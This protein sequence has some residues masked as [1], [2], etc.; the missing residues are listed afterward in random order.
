MTENIA[1]K[2][3]VF[4]FIQRSQE[5]Y[6]QDATLG[7]VLGQIGRYQ[8][9]AKRAYGPIKNPLHLMFTSRVGLST[10]ALYEFTRSRGLPLPDS[11]KVIQTILPIKR[12]LRLTLIGGKDIL[13]TRP[14]LIDF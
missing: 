3:C 5:S 14:N 6:Q 13:D 8:K 7:E 11:N 12:R 9:L 2:S 1:E 10:L 4:K